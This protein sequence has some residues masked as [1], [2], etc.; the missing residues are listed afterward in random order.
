M[1]AKRYGCCWPDKSE[2]GPIAGTYR[3]AAAYAKQHDG[4]V[5]VYEHGERA[6]ADE[7]TPA[8]EAVVPEGAAS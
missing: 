3:D 6:P 4:Y 5:V 1:S 2:T 8:G 7:A